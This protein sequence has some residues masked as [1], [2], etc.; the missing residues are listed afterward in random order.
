MAKKKKGVRKKQKDPRKKANQDLKI[1]ACMMVK[2]EEEMLPRCLNSIKDLVDEIIVVDTGSTDRT[3]GIA[4]SFGAKVYFH[5]WE[6][7]FSKHRNQSI[8]YATGDW[9]IIIDA[10]EELYAR[11]YTKTQLKQLLRKL[12]DNIH[13][14]LFTVRDIKQNGD[15]SHTFASPRLFRSGVG[16]HYKGIVHNNP[17]IKGDV[18]SIDIVINHYGYDL[19]KEDMERKFER[20]T[21]LLSK[22]IEEN[23]QD[24]AVYYYLSNLY[25]FRSD[26]SKTIEYGKKCLELLSCNKH[27]RVPC[28]DALYRIVGRAYAN[29]K[30][31]ENALKWFRKGLKILPDDPDL[32]LEVSAIGAYSSEY[33]LILE[34]GLK[35]LEVVDNF[36]TNPNLAAGRILYSLDKRCEDSTQYNLMNAY[37][38]LGRIEE[39]EER[40]EIVKNVILEKHSMQEEYLKNLSVVCCGEL[41]LERTILFLKKNP[42]S[43][44]LVEPLVL[45][46]LKENTF[47]RAYQQLTTELEDSYSFKA[48]ASYVGRL[49]VKNGAYQI[50]VEVLEP[51]YNLMAAESDLL[52]N[53]A[54]AYDKCGLRD[55]AEQVYLDGVKSGIDDDE[56]L[57]NALNFFKQIGNLTA[58][59]SGIAVLLAKHPSFQEI[60]DDIL[61]FLA[62][63]FFKSKQSHFFLDV[64]TTLFER[65]GVLGFHDLK[66]VDEVANRYES[67]SGVYER[68]GHHSFAL[69]CLNVA[70]LLTLNPYYLVLMGDVFLKIKQPSKAVEYYQLALNKDYL[71]LDILENMKTAFY[72]LDNQEGVELCN[73]LRLKIADQVTK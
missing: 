70:W 53:L 62:E 65:N 29:Q 69:Q 14:V 36:R 21:S 4:R 59:D 15:I 42:D 37:L 24:V 67:I 45:Y 32:N 26:A 72:S 6:N 44:S 73:G 68:N 9:F 3:V 48:L 20:T 56:F 54:L 50:A 25:G 52:L 49:L 8:S 58:L 11:N 43:T 12:P 18:M 30:D 40:W 47:H 27:L 64:S 33:Q 55:R 17:E 61:L 5:A 28:Y 63:H 23:P 7:N 31:Y 35:Y 66:S 71:S 13:A 1:S 19:D 16:F 22:R 51:Y 2:N 10:D 39:A 38:G 57:I 60:P 41:L 34:Y 46:A